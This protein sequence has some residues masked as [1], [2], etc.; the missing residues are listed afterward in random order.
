MEWGLVL[1]V[2]NWL[3]NKRMTD[4]VPGTYALTSS[5]V[6]SGG[7][8]YE[9]CRMTGVVTADGVGP[10]AVEHYCTAPTKRWPHPGQTLPVTVDRADPTR[11][12]VQWDAMPSNHDLARQ[13]AE[14]Q[15]Q[16]LADRMRTGASGTPAGPPVTYTVVG[17]ASRPL[18]GTAGGGL[19][20][21]QAAAATQ[22][23]G[24]M[25]AAH[26]TVLAVHEVIVPAGV[27]GGGAAGTVD[28]TLDVA[29]PAGGGYATSTRI[30]FSTA[31][32]RA[33]V[34]TVGTVLPVLVNPAAH[35]QIAIDATRL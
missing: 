31:A 18:P 33:A 14:Q 17:D 34:A 21:E 23:P 35:D 6:N 8:S 19:T 30:A 24:A 12:E 1:G 32:R 20:P 5:S 26:A 4:P 16:E 29:L 15:A 11:L 13:L 7:A 3:H 28:L 9:N 2:R 27:A 10:V 22:R 25:I